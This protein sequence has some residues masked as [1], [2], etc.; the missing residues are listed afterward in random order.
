MS[1]TYGQQCTDDIPSVDTH[2]KSGD[3]L[4]CEDEG[5]VTVKGELCCSSRLFGWGSAALLAQLHP[6]L[7][8]ENI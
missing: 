6:F 2:R 3:R 1:Y 4:R 5:G 8:T 7:V